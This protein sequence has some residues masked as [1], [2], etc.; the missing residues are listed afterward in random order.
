MSVTLED[1][2]RVAQELLFL[3]VNDVGPVVLNIENSKEMMLGDK[4][5]DMK[6]DTDA[7]TMTLSIVRI[8]DEV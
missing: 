2:L 8:S 3:V 1:E 7:G 4:M 6:L 5:I